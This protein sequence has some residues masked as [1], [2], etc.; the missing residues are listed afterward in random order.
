[1]QHE[2]EAEAALLKKTLAE[3]ELLRVKA[4]DDAAKLRQLLAAQQ[5]E[6]E[7]ASCRQVLH[8]SPPLLLARSLA[9]LSATPGGGAKLPCAPGAASL[10]LA[11]S[12]TPSLPPSLHP[13]L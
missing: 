12:L 11:R 2:L 13:S 8:L 10:S 3:K 9:P 5:L 6:E 7:E 4:R 1:M